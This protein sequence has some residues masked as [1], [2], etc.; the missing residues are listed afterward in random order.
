VFLR[1]PRVRRKNLRDVKERI[2]EAGKHLRKLKNPR[3]FK[4]RKMVH[5]LLQLWPSLKEIE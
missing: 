3:L 4:S 2:G 1:T 5:D